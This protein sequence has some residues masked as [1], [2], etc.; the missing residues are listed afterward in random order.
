LS[1]DV[2]ARRTVV[3]L[4]LKRRATKEEYETAIIADFE[5][6]QVMLEIAGRLGVK[7][8]CTHRLGKEARAV[9]PWFASRHV[10]HVW[11]EVICKRQ[12]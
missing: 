5:V 11:P 10:L 7:L 2:L 6:D 8:P 9:R 1:I 4:A 3:D 12:R